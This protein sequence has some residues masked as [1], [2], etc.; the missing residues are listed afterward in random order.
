MILD[1]KKTCLV[2]DLDGCLVDT[3][4][5]LQ[6]YLWDRYQRW[7]PLDCNRQF[8]V[9]EG[10]F[11]Y[12]ED[13]YDTPDALNAALWEGLW[14]VG[15]WYQQAR[16]NYLY[17]QHL[18]GWQQHALID[19]RYLT[20][21]PSCLKDTTLGW[22]ARW[23]LQTLPGQAVLEGSSAE[24]LKHLRE[25]S[26]EWPEVVYVDDKIATILNVA[27]AKLP[28]VKLIL[29]AQPWNAA[30]SSDWHD[31]VLEGQPAHEH[32]EF[33]LFLH[34]GFEDFRGDCEGCH[35]GL[36]VNA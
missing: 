23:G 19:L 32:K 22:L 13:L 7:V 34:H 24:K 17:W 14:N 35:G 21:R 1:S 18:L 3:W 31:F 6:I 11:R 36:R 20:A 28:N 16:P 9:G 10:I 4:E 33:D 5:M 30:D 2:T 15:T 12:F 27:K 29:F 26:E 8:N 25:W